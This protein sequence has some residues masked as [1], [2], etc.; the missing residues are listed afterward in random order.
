MDCF[1]NI[2]SAYSL[3]TSTCTLNSSTRVCTRAYI[4]TLYNAIDGLE[5]IYFNI[6][7]KC[8]CTCVWFSTFCMNIYSIHVPCM[9]IHNTFCNILNID[10]LSLDLQL[11][12]YS[13]YL[14]P[15]TMHSSHVQQISIH[16]FP[17]T[18]HFI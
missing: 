7:I 5:H 13:I 4:R 8:R 17:I 6:S 11:G 14:Q 2:R 9:Y 10:G 16:Y 12:S 18:Y 3:C 15:L 1:G